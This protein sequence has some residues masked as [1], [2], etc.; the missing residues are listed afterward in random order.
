MQDAFAHAMSA[1]TGESYV[2]ILRAG[3]MPGGVE[4]KAVEKEVAGVLKQS[5]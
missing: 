5:A 2:D 1:F 4:A 3:D